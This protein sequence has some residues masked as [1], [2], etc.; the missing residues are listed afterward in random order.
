M[1]KLCQIVCPL[2]LFSI[3]ISI[4][5]VIN[6]RAESKFREIQANLPFFINVQPNTILPDEVAVGFPV[7]AM[8]QIT[9]PNPLT[10]VN[11]S[12][13]S[14]PPYATI[15]PSGCGKTFTLP[16]QASCTLTLIVSANGLQVGDVI[17]GASSPN[18]LMACWNDGVSCAGVTNRADL[19]R[20]RV[21]SAPSITYQSLLEDKLINADLWGESPEILSANYGFEG[22]E[23]V[24]GNEAGVVA[25]GGAWMNIT[26]PDA[27]YSAY[28][29]AQTPS[30]VAFGFG[31]PTY[32]ADAMP[33]CFSWPVLPST[34]NPS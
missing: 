4:N 10:A 7:H 5:G 32:Y 13:V 24:P 22:I 1:N 2:F 6:A 19:L 34:V 12:I 25:A 8:Y 30:D 20:L 28:T 18:V 31:Y 3:L 27:P 26:T 33:I 17:S 14:L 16:P 23:G 15:S 11:A 9:N 21:I 29:S